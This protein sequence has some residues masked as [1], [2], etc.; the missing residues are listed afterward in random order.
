MQKELHKL[1]RPIRSRLSRQRC[2]PRIASA[3]MTGG[4]L[5][6][7]AALLTLFGGSRTSGLIGIAVVIALPLIALLWSL[8]KSANWEEAARL[9]D[10]RLKLHNR[11]TTAL[12]LA[13][14]A[15]GDAF[16]ALQCEDALKQLR[17]ADLKRVRL[18]VPWQRLASGLVLC[19]FACGLILWGIVAPPSAAIV[20]SGDMQDMRKEIEKRTAQ[21]TGSI[22]S[23]EVRAGLQLADRSLASPAGEPPATLGEDIAGRYFDT[24]ASPPLFK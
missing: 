5:A 20:T 2:L 8:L 10:R 18:A 11:T 22:S 3:L 19:C 13:S 12:S 23:S 17:Q 21:Q 9:V 24:G 14:E 1:L 16:A 6:L 7:V 4:W 15:S